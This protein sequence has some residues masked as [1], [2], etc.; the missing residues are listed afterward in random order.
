MSPVICSAIRS[1]KHAH[2]GSATLFQQ[3]RN[4]PNNQHP[5]EEGPQIRVFRF[6]T[7]CLFQKLP[8]IEEVF[9][10]IVFVWRSI[11]MPATL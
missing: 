7:A 2:P 1:A 5:T 11:I 4:N 9:I 10:Y 8:L 6:W 3:R